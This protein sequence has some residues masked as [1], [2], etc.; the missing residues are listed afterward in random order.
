M[1]VWIFEQPSFGDAYPQRASIKSNGDFEMKMPFG[2][3]AHPECEF[4]LYGMVL[5]PETHF[6]E[7]D[8]IKIAEVPKGQKITP[9]SVRRK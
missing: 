1:S 6:R 8:K 4:Q 5:P 9:I 2:D 3:M 7:M